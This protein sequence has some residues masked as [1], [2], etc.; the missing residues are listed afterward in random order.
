MPTP[1]LAIMWWLLP[2]RERVDVL[3]RLGLAGLRGAEQAQHDDEGEGGEE[4]QRRD[5]P[6]LR[7]VH[8][9]LDGRLGEEPAGDDDGADAVQGVAEV[10]D[11]A[12]AF[13]GDR[14]VTAAIF[15]CRRSRSLPRL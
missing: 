12:A 1:M 11:H 4:S 10:A 13:R 15:A 5:V 14:V 9:F 7:V 6:V 2:R 8:G 3:G